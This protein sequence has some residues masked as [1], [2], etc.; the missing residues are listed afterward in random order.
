MPVENFWQSTEQIESNFCPQDTTCSG[1]T[2]SKSN[3]DGSMHTLS[4]TI[5]DGRDASLA[6]SKS[7]VS[8][9]QKRSAFF[10]A[11]LLLKP[12]QMRLPSDLTG[13]TIPRPTKS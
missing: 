13:A 9:P 5:C 8:H 7:W 11:R 10:P 12:K 2:V 4:L 6:N 3:L 1:L